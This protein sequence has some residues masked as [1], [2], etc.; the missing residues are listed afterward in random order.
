MKKISILMLTAAFLAFSAGAQKTTKTTA[1][2]AV[3]TEQCADCKAAGK[4]PKE[5]AKNHAEGKACDHQVKADAAKTKKLT[6][7]AKV[8]KVAKDTKCAKD[9]NCSQCTHKC[10][11]GKTVKK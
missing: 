10:A 8:K 1:K 4:D 6:K 11:N 9:A 3:K 7:D 2:K 5:C